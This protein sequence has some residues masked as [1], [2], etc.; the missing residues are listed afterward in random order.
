MQ[1]LQRGLSVGKLLRDVAGLVKNVHGCNAISCRKENDVMPSQKSRSAETKFLK[2][3]PIL[4]VVVSEMALTT[5]RGGKRRKWHFC[6][7]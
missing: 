1:P 4:L 6:E 7:R 5:S 3:N 2:V